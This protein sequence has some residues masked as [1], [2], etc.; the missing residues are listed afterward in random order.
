VNI[1]VSENALIMFW[2]IQLLL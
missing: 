2:Q 1:F